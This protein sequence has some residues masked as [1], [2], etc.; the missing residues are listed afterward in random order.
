MGTLGLSQFLLVTSA[1]L[2]LLENYILFQER[3][4][5]EDGRWNDEVF[6]NILFIP[7]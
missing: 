5:S 7:P 3:C 1:L 6:S 2:M 4:L